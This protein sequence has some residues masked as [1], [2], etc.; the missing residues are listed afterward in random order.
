MVWESHGHFHNK[1][2]GSQPKSWLLT[3]ILTPSLFSLRLLFMALS[4]DSKSMLRK[5]LPDALGS[6]YKEMV[7]L[8]FF[9]A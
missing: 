5:E 3:I 2:V 6:H 8:D 1:T 9:I 4:R 7:P